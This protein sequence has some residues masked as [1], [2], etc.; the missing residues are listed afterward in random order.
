MSAEWHV[1]VEFNGSAEMQR[2]LFQIFYK[3]AEFAIAVNAYKCPQVF[4]IYI[5]R[6]W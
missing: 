1:R 5:Y 4:K 3:N 2:Q 6:Y